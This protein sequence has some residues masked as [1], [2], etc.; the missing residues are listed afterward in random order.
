MRTKRVVSPA[1][2]AKK[3]Q[4]QLTLR[5]TPDIEDWLAARVEAEKAR[6][7]GRKISTSDIVRDCLFEAMAR[8][9]K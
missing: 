9:S 5:V 3:Y 8:K 6:A 1:P 2:P 4:G 7:P